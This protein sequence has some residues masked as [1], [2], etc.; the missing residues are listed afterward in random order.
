[1]SS[2]FEPLRLLR[3]PTL[4]LGDYPSYLAISVAVYSVLFFILPAGPWIRKADPSEAAGSKRAK[5]LDA[6]SQSVQIRNGHVSTVHAIAACVGI[7]VWLA[8]FQSFDCWAW[9][10]N[11]QGGVIS[12]PAN[13]T[14]DEWLVVLICNTLGQS[15]TH[16]RCCSMRLHVATD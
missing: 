15:D 9:Q 13:V 7:T 10:R 4:P 6:H 5:P 3:A 8:Y 2:L 12:T 11:M 1:M 16:D 14:G